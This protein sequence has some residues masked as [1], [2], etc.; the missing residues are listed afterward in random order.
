LIDYQLPVFS[1]F[2]P[3]SIRNCL[4]LSFLCSHIFLILCPRPVSYIHIS[5]SHLIHFVRLL[6]FW[7]KKI[8]AHKICSPAENIDYL[9]I[10]YCGRTSNGSSGLYKA[11]NCTIVLAILDLASSVYSTL[12]PQFSPC[13]TRSLKP[14]N[15]HVRDKNTYYQIRMWRA[16]YYNIFSHPKHNQL[17][18]A[19]SGQPK[20]G[21]KWPCL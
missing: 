16:L 6:T 21:R 11:N 7:L 10:S 4:G 2:R 19:T 20:V 5:H 12:G 8:H 18:P 1:I 15:C 14:D 17:T 9:E 3:V 13:F